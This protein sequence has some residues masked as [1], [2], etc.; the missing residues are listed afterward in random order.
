VGVVPAKGKRRESWKEAVRKKSQL[1]PPFDGGKIVPQ[2]E[3]RTR[4]RKKAL[5][6]EEEIGSEEGIR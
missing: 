3:G 1:A 4:R 5:D 6:W 2:A